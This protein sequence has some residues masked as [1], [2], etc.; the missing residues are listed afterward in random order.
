[1]FRSLI[2]IGIPVSGDRDS[3]RPPGPRSSLVTAFSAAAACSRAS[4]GCHRVEGADLLVQP[5]DAL[6]VVLGDLDR[7]RAAGPDRGGQLGHGQVMNVQSRYRTVD[8]PRDG[9]PAATGRAACAARP[10][11]TAA[12]AMPG[13]APWPYT[14]RDPA[15]AKTPPTRRSV[16]ALLL[17]ELWT[18]NPGR[19]RTD[20]TGGSRGPGAGQLV[21]APAAC[22]VA[23]PLT[24][25]SRSGLAAPSWR[26]WSEPPSPSGLAGGSA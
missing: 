25:G 2:G 1:M 5:V 3:T 7:G 13:T 11:T 8:G 22:L 12:V 4:S 24:R 15:R 6:Q 9:G 26:W 16:S 19:R 21:P 20:R 18:E 14:S 10:C 17:S 23:W